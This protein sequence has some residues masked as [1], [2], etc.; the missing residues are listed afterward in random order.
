MAVFDIPKRPALSSWLARLTKTARRFPV[1]LTAATLVLTIGL[2]PG[3][4]AAS[5][6]RLTTHFGLRWA[7]LGHQPW[8]LA[9]AMFVQSKPGVRPT[10]AALLAMFPIVERRLGSRLTLA[11]MLFGDWISTISVLLALRIAAANHRSWAAAEL[12]LRDGGISSAVHAVAATAIAASRPS[13]ARSV[14]GIVALA[15]V[16]QRLVWGRQLFDIQHAVAAVVGAGI[17]IAA[18]HRRSNGRA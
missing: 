12:V 8:R 15:W 11:A 13:P 14:A 16:L 9:T 6:L 18:R 2:G 10:I 5:H 1:S 7:D 3:R 4:V 17:G